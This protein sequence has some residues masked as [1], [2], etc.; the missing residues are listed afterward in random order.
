MKKYDLYKFDTMTV[1]EFRA[2]SNN[3]MANGDSESGNAIAN[4]ALSKRGCQYVWGANGPDT[5]DCSGLVWWACNENGVKFERTTA[6]QLSKMGKSVKYEELQAGDIITF[7]TDPSYVSHV[8]IYIG[9]G[10]MVHAPNRTTVVKVQQITSGYYY[11]RIY[12]CRRLKNGNNYGFIFGTV[13]AFIVFVLLIT[14]KMWLPDDRTKM[15]KNNNTEMYFYMIN[16]E[17]GDYYVDYKNNLAEIH[18]KQYVGDIDKKYS[19]NFNV[20]DSY[21]NKL[22]TMLV[23]GNK[24]RDND[25]EDE[26][27]PYTMKS[28]LQVGIPDDLYYLRIDAVQKDNTTQQIFIDYRNMKEKKILEK[29]KNYLKNYE[30][31]LIKMNTLDYEINESKI[32]IEDIKQS[33]KDYNNLP[34][35][36]KALNPDGLNNLNNDL[37]AENDTLESLEK[38]LKKQKKIVEKLE[39]VPFTVGDKK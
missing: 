20:Y 30:N 10:Q 12:N 7:K 35:D 29:G 3:I 9:N 14:S 32:A 34:D 24:E 19:L 23:D 21:G 28:I 39:D 26:S 5:F 11:E 6:S 38:D 2:D 8:G 15:I 36:Q 27:S 25:D 4:S 18:L 31:E 13:I 22:P 17:T 1:E 16:L 37:N 33:I